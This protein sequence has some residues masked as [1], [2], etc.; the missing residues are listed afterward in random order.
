MRSTFRTYIDRFDPAGLRSWIRNDPGRDFLKELTTNAPA[1][2]RLGWGA[3]YPDPDNFMQLFTSSSANN[4]TGWGSEEFD[5]LVDRAA[6]ERDPERRQQLYDR[7]QV[8]LL[9]RDVAIVPFF[10]TSLNLALAERVQGYTPNAMDLLMLE[11]VR[12]Q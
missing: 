3:D 9:E 2:Y 12:A 7:A 1:V 8:I 10:V 5:R 11:G 6:R 4:H